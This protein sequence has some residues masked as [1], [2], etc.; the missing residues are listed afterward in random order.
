MLSRA[1]ASKPA[2]AQLGQ[3]HNCNHK[4]NYNYYSNY[5]K[6][7]IHSSYNYIGNCNK[8]NYT[9]NYNKQ[10]Y[11]PPVSFYLMNLDIPPPGLEPGS[12]G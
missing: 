4:Y 5:K 10:K 6:Y 12:L 2:I 9:S 3:N 1:S 11:P 7:N 8:H